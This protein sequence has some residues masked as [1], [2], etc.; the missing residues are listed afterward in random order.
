MNSPLLRLLARLVLQLPDIEQIPT[1]QR[2]IVAL[3]RL[4]VSLQP[5]ME[6]S[7]DVVLHPRFYHPRGVRLNFADGA[8]IKRDVRIGRDGE[9]PG[10]ATL[11]IGVGSQ[12][13]SDCHLDCSSDITIGD[14]THIGRACSIYTHT[15]QTDSREVPVL[16]S[17]VNTAPVVIG[18]DVMIYSDV[19][20]LPGIT[21]GD[22]AVVAVRSVVTRD[23]EPYAIVA[24][25]PAEKVGE[26]T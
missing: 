21:I 16:E 22:G 7:D 11:S 20:I 15:H 5:N 4:L 17:P 19:V 14:G 12:I 1:Y 6:L 24:G 13:L 9:V 25:V 10:E 23:V 3:R 26:R 18:S 2:Q 8:E